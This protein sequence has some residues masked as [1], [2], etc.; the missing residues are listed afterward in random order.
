MTEVSFNSV[1]DSLGN[2]KRGD[3]FGVLDEMILFG[4][5]MVVFYAR[6][7]GKK[8][9]NPSLIAKGDE[10]K[11][12]GFMESGSLGKT[13]LLVVSIFA[14]QQPSLR[15]VLWEYLLILLGRWNGEAILMG[16]YNEVRTNV[17]RRACI[18]SVCK[19]KQLLEVVF[20]A[21]SVTGFYIHKSQIWGSG[22]LAGYRVEDMASS[23]VCTLMEKQV[24]LFGVMVGLGWTR[25][26]GLGDWFLSTSNDRW[27]SPLSSSGGMSVI[28]T[29]LAIDDLVLP[30]HAEPTRLEVLHRV[31]IGG[32]VRFPA[33]AFVLRMGS[34]SVL[35]FRLRVEFK[36][37]A[38]C[39]LR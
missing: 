32:R 1:G 36:V 9:S 26:K 15:R 30:Y 11:T 10:C 21:F 5:A 2:I 12:A 23:L 25:H 39:L 27:Y 29:R 14:P 28:V 18:L 24:S 38:R 22:G 16:D 31:C 17:E 35:F 37:L 19:V 34:S 7:C 8:I 6:G 13:M 33:L 4:R 3:C 20:K